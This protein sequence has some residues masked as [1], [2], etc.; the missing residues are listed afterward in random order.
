MLQNVNTFLISKKN[1]FTDCYKLW[2]SPSYAKVEKGLF[3]SEIS[4]NHRI[5]YKTLV[6]FLQQFKFEVE[7]I[8][9]LGS[10]KDEEKNALYDESFLNM[11]QRLDIEKS[12][13]F[14]KSDSTINA[15]PAM[16]AKGSI[17][18]LQIIQILITAFWS[19]CTLKISE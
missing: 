16:V 18:H 4:K 6:D 10:A 3:F 9:K 12:L 13:K 7:V 15:H 14:S 1:I 11:L 17:L 8:Q 19:D 2:H 5:S